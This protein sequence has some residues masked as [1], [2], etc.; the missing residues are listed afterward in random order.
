MG[1][2]RGARLI[3][4]TPVLGSKTASFESLCIF[5]EDYEMFFPKGVL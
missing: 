1:T 2:G 4:R 5:K 3:F